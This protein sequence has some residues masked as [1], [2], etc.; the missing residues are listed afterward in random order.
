[1]NWK[2]SIGNRLLVVESVASLAKS[3]REIQSP[4]GKIKIKDAGEVAERL[5]AAV[6]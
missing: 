5:K 1:M 2:V 3:G 4:S 6:C